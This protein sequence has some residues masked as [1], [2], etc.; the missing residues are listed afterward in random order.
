MRTPS[1]V[2]PGRA[3]AAT[4]RSWLFPGIIAAFFVALFAL[5]RGAA[6]GPPLTYTQFVADV[7]AGTVRAVTIGP[8]GQVTG[9]LTSGQPFSTTIPVALG[10]NGL[11]GDLA[12][13][14]VQVTAAAA[15][16]P[17]LLSV[18]AGLLPL[19]LIGGLIYFVIRGARRQARGLGGGL[20]GLTSVTKA[21]ARVI[22]GERPATRFTDVA[23]YSGV[24]TEISEVVDY[25]RDPGRYQRAEARG[26]RG[27]LMAG[28]PGTGK[29]LL[30]RA[31][32]GEAGVPFFSIS[33]SDFVEMFVGV[34]A[35]R[36]RD[37]FEQAKQ[38]APA[39]IFVDEIDAVG[40]HR[41]AGMGGGHD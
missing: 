32:A 7:G 31:V 22:D 12:A 16:A 10:G 19:L 41:G 13:H 29:T 34:G 9:S 3:N 11:A 5:P 35:S 38:N 14:H 37:L 4:W 6:A 8:A 24:K 18:L 1:P 21:K 23:G 40:R 27:V 15:T 20:G 25:L 28:P 26:P 39:I 33:G 30:A 36:V 2:P 17:S